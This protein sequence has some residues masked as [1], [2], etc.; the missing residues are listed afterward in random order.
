[1]LEGMTSGIRNR[2]VRGVTLDLGL[3]FG[4]S[5]ILFACSSPNSAWLSI[6]EL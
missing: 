5:F 3:W 6:W 2:K 4:I 1:M